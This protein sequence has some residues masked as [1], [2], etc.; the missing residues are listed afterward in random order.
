MLL[1]LRDF[2]LF[3]M[4]DPFVPRLEAWN[5]VLLSNPGAE[6]CGVCTLPS[7]DIYIVN[8]SDRGSMPNSVV[9]L[10]RSSPR[11][12]TAV[13][14]API[15]IMGGCAT[16]PSGFQ[17]EGSSKC[18]KLWGPTWLCGAMSNLVVMNS[19]PGPF[20]KIYLLLTF[21]RSSAT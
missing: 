6:L 3:E 5:R 18:V 9:Q 10:P 2:R 16:Y 15:L 19:G 1:L 17:Y 12:G 8:Q 20:T 14:S 11:N 7:G 4:I 13:F 21:F